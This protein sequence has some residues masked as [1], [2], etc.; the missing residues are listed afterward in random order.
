MPVDGLPVSGAYRHFAR[1]VAFAALDR[2]AE[3]E[4]E[5]AAFRAALPAVPGD[6][7]WGSNAAA[8]VLAVAV[9]YLDGEIAYRKRRLDEA[10]TKLREAVVLED[11]LKYDEPPP[12]TVPARHSLGAVLIAS[13]AYP[14]AEA[15]YRDDLARYPENGWALRGLA[16]ALT[17]QGRSAEAASVAARLEKAWARAD[18]KVD[19]SCLCVRPARP[20]GGR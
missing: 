11:A 16:Q 15:V 1:G 18:V 7:F 8:A 19:S 20:S 2:L 14:E 6:A 3:A 17:A 4:A 10:A 9:P 5:A 13:K 12:W